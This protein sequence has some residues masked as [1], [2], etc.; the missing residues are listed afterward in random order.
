MTS[1]ARGA[2]TFELDPLTG[3]VRTSTRW[4]PRPPGSLLP[5]S[6]HPDALVRSLPVP[7]RTDVAG[8]QAAAPVDA[9]ADPAQ[10]RTVVPLLV[11]WIDAVA[12]RGMLR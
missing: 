10:A 6:T 3:R 2:S 9:P 5:R 7:A 1:G 12:Q 4:S 11:Q 8:N